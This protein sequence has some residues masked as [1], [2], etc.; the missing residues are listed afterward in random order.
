MITIET[1][2]LYAIILVITLVFIVFV[3]RAVYMLLNRRDPI[4]AITIHPS[5][6]KILKWDK[7]KVDK[8]IRS[9]MS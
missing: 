5:E 3:L 6:W 1:I 8:K 2:K 4:N 9:V 7:D